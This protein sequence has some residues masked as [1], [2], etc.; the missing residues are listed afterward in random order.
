MNGSTSPD[1]LTGY[2]FVQAD[3]SA[4]LIPSVV[5]VA[6]TLTLSSS[7]ITT[8]SSATL[9]WSSANTTG[10][11]AS[12]SWSGALASSGSQTVTPAAAGS[13]TYSLTC[14][15]AAGSSPTSSVTLTVTAPV[16]TSS[17]HGGG[18]IGVPMLIGLAAL[19]LRRRRS[20]QPTSMRG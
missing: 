8:G 13:D 10:C 16:A 18:A 5:P 7:A 19:S 12:G 17:S 6:P 11:T 1:Y 9:T 3:A 2:G 15:N 20:L 14:A 4:A